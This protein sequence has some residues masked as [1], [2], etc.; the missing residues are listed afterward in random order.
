MITLR[1]KQQV[2]RTVKSSSEL[3]KKSILERLEIERR[4]WTTKNIEWGIITQK[5]ILTVMAKNIEWIHQSLDTYEERG[6][7]KEK[8]YQLAEILVYELR[9]SNTSIR[10]ITANFDKENNVDVGTGLFI[11]KHLLATKQITTDMGIK[12][13]IAKSNPDISIHWSERYASNQ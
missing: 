4:Y 2:A 10:K 1:N 9:N 3:E 11:F 5:E 6:L 7:A 13:D 12:I 8:L